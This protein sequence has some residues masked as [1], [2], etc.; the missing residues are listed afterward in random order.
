MSLL[1]E[2]EGVARRVM[3]LI[4][5][6]DTSSSMQGNKINAVNDAIVKVLPML[7]DISKNNADAQIKVGALEFSSGAKWLYSDL[8]N[9]SDFHWQNVS[10]GGLTSMGEACE[11]LEK[12]LHR[13]GGFMN[14][15]SGMF[16]PAFILLSDGVPTDD[17]DT[18]I[19][20]LNA[21][22]WFQSGIKIAI[23]IGEE[24]DKCTLA[25]F[26]G[27]VESV[28]TVNNIDALKQII[29]IVSITSSQVGSRSSSVNNVSKQDETVQNINNLNEN[30]DNWYSG[31]LPG[32]SLSAPSRNNTFTDYYL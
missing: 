28:I 13:N 18:G 17:F 14:N 11:E 24:A 22:R 32:Q 5:I 3:P 19:Q 25:K 1:D 15:A 8:H 27:N 31:L 4:F 21:N 9:A 29:R 7:D 12:K 23:A 30:N 6:I 16:A 20:E 10:A 26:T 2:T